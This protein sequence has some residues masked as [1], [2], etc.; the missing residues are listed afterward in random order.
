MRFTIRRMM[1]AVAIVAAALGLGVAVHHRKE[2][3][4]RLAAYHS[5]EA[6]YEFGEAYRGVGC[7][8]HALAFR[9]FPFGRSVVD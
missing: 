5:E 7:S 8:V 6:A 2:R 9:A 3:W 4:L 1:L